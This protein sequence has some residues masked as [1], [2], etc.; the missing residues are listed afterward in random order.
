MNELVVKQ[1]T[2]NENLEF[3]VYKNQIVT[4]ES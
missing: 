3:E 1:T 4:W 2:E